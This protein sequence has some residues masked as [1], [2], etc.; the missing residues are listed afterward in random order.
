MKRIVQCVPNF[1]EGRRKEVVDAIAAEIK[2]ENVKLLDVEMDADHNRSVMTFV[3]EPEDAKKALLKAAGKAV[4]LID[5]EKHQGEHPRVG[6]L[7]VVPFVPIKNVTTEECVTLAKEV[8]SAL[9]EMGIPV[10][11]YEDAA[12]RPE[13]KNLAKVRKGQYEGL[14]TEIETNPDKKPDFGPSKLHPSAGA[15][16]VGARMPLIAYNVNLNTND[17]DIAK[18]IASKVRER[19][20][21]LPSVKAMG[22]EIKERNIVQVSMNLTNFNVTGVWKAFEEV[23]KEAESMGVEVIGSEIVGTVPLEA[24]VDCADNLLKLEKFKFDQILETRLWEA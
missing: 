2:T 20:G 17:I 4:E 22:F 7:D 9:G 24:L 23:R 21:G 16:V 8:G 11:L 10:Y 3:G 5:M 15:T 13:R 12:T 1:S 19:G 18:K 14:K 6:A